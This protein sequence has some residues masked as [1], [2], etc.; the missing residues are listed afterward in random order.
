MSEVANLY[1]VGSSP[2]LAFKIGI[3]K[4]AY[5]QLV[6]RLLCMQEAAGSSP[7][8][9]ILIHRMKYIIQKD[10]RNRRLFHKVEKTQRALKSVMF[11]ERQN[12]EVRLLAHKNLIKLGKRGSRTK[13]HNRCIRSGRSNSV[14]RKFKISRIELRELSRNGSIPGY[15]KKSW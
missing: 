4:G 7:A 14:Y 9:S 13:I 3:K 10:K 11:D 1:N 15:T 12:E 6:D 8:V 2:T 5:R